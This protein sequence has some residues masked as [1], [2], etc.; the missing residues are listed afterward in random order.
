MITK[1]KDWGNS[2]GVRIPKEILQEAGITKEDDLSI[3]ISEGGVFLKK[4]Q[5][6][7]TL[8]ER[9]R[10]CGKKSGPYQE[11]NWGESRGRENWK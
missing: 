10:E 3:S 5:R 9:A 1:I 11:Y 6:H 7:R 8:E 2:Q 4:I